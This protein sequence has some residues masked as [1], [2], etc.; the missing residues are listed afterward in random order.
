MEAKEKLKSHVQVQEKGMLIIILARQDYRHHLS[1]AW[2]ADRSASA[3]A[4]A[5]T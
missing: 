4:A 5:S 1:G 3:S 2:L